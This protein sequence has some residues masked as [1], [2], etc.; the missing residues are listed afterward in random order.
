MSGERPSCVIAPR[1]TGFADS[2][3]EEFSVIR[4]M[5]ETRQAT[6]TRGSSGLFSHKD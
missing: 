4:R 1:T 2:E 6:R 5:S 3:G